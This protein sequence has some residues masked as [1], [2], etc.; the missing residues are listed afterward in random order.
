MKKGDTMKLPAALYRILLE[1][2]DEQQFI[3]MNDILR[4]LQEDYDI[5]TE[6]KTVY[7]ARDALKECG[8]EICH[9]RRDGRQGYYLKHP[10]TPGESLFLLDMIAESSALSVKK[11]KELSAKVTALMSAHEQENLPEIFQSPAKTDNQKVPENIEILM[12]AIAAH[13]TV[14]F[15]YYDIV[16]TDH[17]RTARHYRKDSRIYLADPYGIVTGNGRVYCVTYNKKYRHQVLYRLDKIE[18]LQDTG[19]PFDP[20][21]FDI[22]DYV[23]RSVQ[24]YGGT[25]QSVQ[26]RFSKKIAQNVFDEFGRPNENVIIQKVDQDTFD[27]TLKTSL[28]PTVTGWFLQF[29]QD[30]K[31]LG[32]QSFRQELLNIAASIEK[33]Y[34]NDQKQEDLE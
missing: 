34:N 6:R 15:C 24:M 14:Q 26:A 17:A 30:A 20:V 16:I 3:S 13:H 23:R 31:V 1:H 32:P 7:A 27:A 12:N 22:E 18:K 21:Y 5:K 19:T 33:N 11:S 9:V 10:F 8:I 28:T 25:S 29:Y 2:S 4:F